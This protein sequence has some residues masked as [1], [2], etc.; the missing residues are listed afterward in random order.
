LHVSRHQGLLGT[1]V[2][3]RLHAETASAAHTCESRVVAEI[4]RLRHVLSS[5]DESSDL[6]RWQRGETDPGPE[7]SEVLA[8]AATW[9][10]RSDG[11]FIVSVGVLTDRWTRAAQVDA[12]PEP[13]A[14]RETV[15]RCVTVPCEIKNS[16]VGRPDR[17]R[18]VDVNGIAKGW[19]MDRAASIAFACPGVT[20]VMINAGGDL[21]HRG[22]LGVTVGIE[23]P[24]R[25][26]H[27]R[28][29]LR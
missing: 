13:E 4:A 14:L 27:G 11:A 18:T 7:L 21:A 12:L 2:E 10:E 20:D 1:V 9:Q 8:L 23:D 17:S 26:R 15:Q 28:R 25:Q 5:F 19:I 29:V 22:P 3:C 16:A 24:A 6:C